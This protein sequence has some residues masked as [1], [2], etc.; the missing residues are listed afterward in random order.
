MYYLSG[1]NVITR[2][3]ESRRGREKRL[4]KGMRGW[5]NAGRD[6]RLLAGVAMKEEGRVLKA[7]GAH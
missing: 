1:T 3:L 5:Q 4:G 2:I 6:T 7:M